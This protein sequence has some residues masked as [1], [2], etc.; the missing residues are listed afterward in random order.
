[1]VAVVLVV[2]HWIPSSNSTW[3]LAL[4]FA[5]VKWLLALILLL[6][7]FL[8][9]ERNLEL[10]STIRTLLRQLLARV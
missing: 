6:P 10:L 2:D 4:Q 5:I 3:L 7:L 8:V 1:L 9:A